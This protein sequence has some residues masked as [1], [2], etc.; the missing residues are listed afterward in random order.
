MPRDEHSIGT[1]DSLETL[2]RVRRGAVRVGRRCDVSA[3]TAM[4]DVAGATLP[5]QVEAVALDAAVRT[6]RLVPTAR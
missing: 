2:I 6:V 1:D 5:P 3:A 4:H